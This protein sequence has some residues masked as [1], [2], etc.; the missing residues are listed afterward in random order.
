MSLRC[1]VRDYGSFPNK[2]CPR[3]V[4]NVIWSGVECQAQVLCRKQG[5]YERWG[6][7]KAQTGNRDQ[8]SD[9]SKLSSRFY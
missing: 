3:V 8:A 4:V 2:Q 7:S 6:T 9:G 5:R 1:R